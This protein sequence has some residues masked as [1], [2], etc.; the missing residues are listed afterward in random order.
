[1]GSCGRFYTYSPVSRSWIRPQVCLLRKRLLYC[2]RQ[3]LAV[4]DAKCVTEKIVNNRKRNLLVYQKPFIITNSS[5]IWLQRIPWIAGKWMF[6]YQKIAW[7]ISKCLIRTFVNGFKRS[8]FMYR[9]LPM[10][11]LGYIATRPGLEVH[12][13]ILLLGGVPAGASCY[14]S[15][16]WWEGEVEQANL[17]LLLERPSPSTTQ[18]ESWDHQDLVRG[19][20]ALVSHSFV[21]STTTKTHMRSFEHREPTYSRMYTIIPTNGSVVLNVILQYSFAVVT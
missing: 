19:I 17:F 1:M 9:F 5:Q 20:Y 10:P 6:P 16:W 12:W 14:S 18:E 7:I 15:L 2:I 8:C 13:A 3:K 4:L 11:P 21:V